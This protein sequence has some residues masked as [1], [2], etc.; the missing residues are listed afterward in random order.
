MEA[1][2]DT[3]GRQL[4]ALYR[5]N[6]FMAHVTDLRH[7]LTAI[8]DESKAVVQCEAS[9][10]MLYDEEKN[11]LFFEV[12][13]GEKGEAVKQIRLKADEGIAGDCAQRRQTI[14][15]EN[16]ASDP[17]HAK[18]VDEKSKFETRNLIATPLLRGDRLIGVLEVLNKNG[19]QQ[20][21]EEDV[22]I[23]RFFADQ[24]AIALE[25]AILVQKAVANERL[26][27]TGIAVLSI[28]HFIKNILTGMKGGASLVDM[29]VKQKSIAPVETAWPIIQRSLLKISN[30]VNDMLLYSKE[31][32]PEY[33][34]TDLNGLMSDVVQTVQDTA[35]G[36]KIAVSHKPGEGDI[37]LVEMDPSPV[38]D[39]VLNIV[40]NGIDACRGI[41]GGA[42]QIR[43]DL[44]KENPA[45]FTIQIV[46]NGPGIPEEVRAKI[47]EAF[48]STKGS[49][50]TG[51]GLAVA[52]K[53]AEEHGGSL[54]VDSEEGSGAKFTFRLPRRS[55]FRK[56]S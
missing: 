46:D 47:F 17:R 20:F 11:E 3:I 14:V 2:G 56:T 48:F 27:A 36:A 31:R 15:V 1:R 6:N 45:F 53:V 8:M 12:A 42:V 35:R 33:I 10:L 9:A 23:I 40:V 13:L 51:L 22:K 24:A 30:L 39:A 50:G 54:H 52:K 7:L 21:T 55:E 37:G 43:T 32:K 28:S 16:V 26:A 34:E 19:G 41:E 38:L 44:D 25:N 18:R 29:G 5:V 49:K 4:D